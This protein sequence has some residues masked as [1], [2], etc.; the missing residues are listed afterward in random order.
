[1][2]TTAFLRAHCALKMTK[3]S[4]EWCFVYKL[5]FKGLSTCTSVKV[6]GCGSDLSV[7][8]IAHNILVQLY[9]KRR[10]SFSG[11]DRAHS[12]MYTSRC[13]LFH[14]AAEPTTTGLLSII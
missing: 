2:S 1:M 8:S 10:P 11:S 3:S 14:G 5:I 13:S 9:F 4:R 12:Q 6:A 7:Y